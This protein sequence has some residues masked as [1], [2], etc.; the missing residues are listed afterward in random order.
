MSFAISSFW[1][2]AQYKQFSAAMTLT[3]L[4]TNQASISNRSFVSF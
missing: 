1:Q 2:L 3:K 4:A